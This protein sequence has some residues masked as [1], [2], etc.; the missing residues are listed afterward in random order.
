[1]AT[2]D[3]NRYIDKLSRN[4][5]GSVKGKIRLRLLNN[6]L[7]EFCCDFDRGGLSILDAGCG[8][9]Q[10]SEGCLERGHRVLLLDLEEQMIERAAQRISPYLAA[11]QAALECAD[12]L[13][14]Q[15]TVPSLFDLIFLHG[16]AEWMDDA[17]QAIGKACHLLRDG[18]T[19]SL[20]MFNRDVHMFK[21]GINGHLGGQDPNRKQKLFP[22][23][24]QRVARTVEVLGEQPGKILLQ[25]GIRIFYGFFRESALADVS[26]ETWLMQEQQFYREPPFSSLGQH[27]HFV[28][29]KMG[30]NRV[31]RNNGE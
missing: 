10:F 7:R 6:D 15:P 29:Q 3:F 5:Y 27:T 31:G 17:T 19:L 24:A 30:S 25:S 18:G 14:W 13:A 4:V 9:G 11:G 16:S 8:E 1:M 21:K 2:A 26:E 28:W 12:F 22:P 23:Q 20:L